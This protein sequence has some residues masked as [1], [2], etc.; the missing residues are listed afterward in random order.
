MPPNRTHPS[1]ASHHLRYYEQGQS[2][3]WTYFRCARATR[4]ND[5]P[6]LEFLNLSD[7]DP[8]TAQFQSF[9]LT[10]AARHHKLSIRSSH[11]TVRP[12]YCEQS[13]TYLVR[14]VP[15]SLLTHF[16]PTS[17]STLCTTFLRFHHSFSDELILKRDPAQL[18]H[19]APCR[20][21]QLERTGS[22]LLSRLLG[23][24]T[25]CD[26]VLALELRIACRVLQVSLYTHTIPS[27]TCDIPNEV[28]TLCV[29][30]NLV[31]I[32]SAQNQVQGVPYELAITGPSKLLPAPN[33]EG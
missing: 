14:G 30:H 22:C 13:C 28:L 33:F 8:P 20:H 2:P 16:V 32:P 3:N 23:R 17:A 18:T 7:C 5:K 1:G 10:P 31:R 24:K 4:P 9:M 15:R 12:H 29:S 11:L 27:S 25:A 19:S 26:C 6:I 21:A